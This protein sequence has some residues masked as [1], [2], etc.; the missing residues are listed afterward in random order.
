MDVKLTEQFW[1]V[2]NWPGKAVSVL[3][4]AAKA[5]TR[6]LY[7]TSCHDS[8]PTWVAILKS[9]PDISGCF[10]SCVNTVVTRYQR[11]CPCHDVPELKIAHTS[12]L[13][14]WLLCFSDVSSKIGLLWFNLH[15]MGK[16]YS[17][18]FHFLPRACLNQRQRRERERPPRL[19]LPTLEGGGGGVVV[20]SFNFC[21][22][23][24]L[25]YSA[26]L[27][28]RAGSMRSCSTRFSMSDCSLLSCS[29]FWMAIE[30]S[31]AL[32]ALFGRDMAGATWNCCRLGARSLEANN[33]A[34]STVLLSCNTCS[35]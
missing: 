34:R 8:N 25:L 27:C 15:F 18:S 7:L 31:G 14:S 12:I 2:Q 20:W 35:P 29:T 11:A 3:F 24:S 16:S 33:Y 1:H 6:S 22:Y 5:K 28:S 30:V 10:V 23:C 19:S 4:W 21:Y 26:V 9:L 32:T 13:P 17:Q